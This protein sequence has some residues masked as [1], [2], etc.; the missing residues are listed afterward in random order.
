[1]QYVKNTD[2]IEPNELSKVYEIP[3]TKEY[4]TV[5]FNI[6]MIYRKLKSRIEEHI[7]NMKYNKKTTALSRLYNKENLQIN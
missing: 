5:Q 7:P 3:F 4:G 2:L 1:M 6:G